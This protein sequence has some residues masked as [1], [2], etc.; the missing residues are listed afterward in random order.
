[1]EQQT[2]GPRKK[3]GAVCCGSCSGLGEPPHQNVSQ[4]PKAHDHRSEYADV[5]PHV[6]IREPAAGGG[7]QA[8]AEAGRCQQPIVAKHV[9]VLVL[10][11][12]LPRISLLGRFDTFDVV[13]PPQSPA[14]S[15]TALPLFYTRH[16]LNRVDL[17]SSCLLLL[18]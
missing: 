4:E 13:Q 7:G 14:V 18:V 5:L 9:T 6:N 10:L 17:E 3:T 2:P 16:L 12:S 8:G 1:M 15:K 11:L